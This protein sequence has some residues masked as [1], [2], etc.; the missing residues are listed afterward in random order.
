M[1]S[2]HADC[3]E[4]IGG[5]RKGKA[6]NHS[7]LEARQ[8]TRVGHFSHQ[9]RPRFTD[10]RCDKIWSMQTGHHREPRPEFTCIGPAQRGAEGEIGV[11]LH[12]HKSAGR[13][14][15]SRRANQPPHAHIPNH[16]FVGQ[17]RSHRCA[18]MP[19]RQ[20]PPQSLSLRRAEPTVQTA[21]TKMRQIHYLARRAGQPV[22]S[23][24]HQ[25]FP[26]RELF[27]RIADEHPHDISL[28]GNRNHAC[29][30]A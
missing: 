24:I 1:R 22:R 11:V 13:P 21:H 9:P 3:G 28:L 2:K 10:G 26:T 25:W 30:H 19:T 27:C 8:P 12:S 4:L 5:R 7:C 20:A 16:C 18:P 17:P 23:I 6:G 15:K 29:R 14:L